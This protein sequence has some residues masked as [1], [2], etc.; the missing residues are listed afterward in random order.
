MSGISP[1]LASRIENSASGV[2]N[3]KS[4]ASASCNPPTGM[5]SRRHAQHAS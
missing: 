3:R 5:R 4:A 1:H 2:V